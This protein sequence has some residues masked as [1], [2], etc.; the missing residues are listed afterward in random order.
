MGKCLLTMPTG[1]YS[2]CPLGENVPTL[3][4]LFSRYSHSE[5]VV[6]PLRRISLLGASSPVDARD[7]V[8]DVCMYTIVNYIPTTTVIFITCVVGILLLMIK[9]KM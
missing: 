6:Y 5:N 8:C 9:K 1:V 2:K 7:S 4:M 3:Q